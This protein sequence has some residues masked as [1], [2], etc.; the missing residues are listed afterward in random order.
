MD[1]N[2]I[3]TVAEQGVTLNASKLP[4]VQYFRVQLAGVTGKK[5]ERRATRYLVM[6]KCE[7]VNELTN[8]P[9]IAARHGMKLKHNSFTTREA[10]IAGGKEYADKWGK[11]TSK[12]G[13]EK[14]S[15]IEKATAQVVATM[16]AKL[17]D[18]GLSADAINAIIA[19]V[20]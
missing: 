7:G 3:T 8:A 13:K 14:E 11:A 19:T 18:M 10:A 9:D 16:T 12:A 4:K 1:I 20:K 17:K 6:V 5:D 2:E 15:A